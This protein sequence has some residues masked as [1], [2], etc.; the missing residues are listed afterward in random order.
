MHSNGFAATSIWFN[1]SLTLDSL[2]GNRITAMWFCYQRGSL[3][4]SNQT[5]STNRIDTNILMVP[6]N[7]RSLPLLRPRGAGT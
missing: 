1:P 6:R 4:A 7:G 5:T 2:V 3:V